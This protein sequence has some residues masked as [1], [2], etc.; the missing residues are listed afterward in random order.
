M[1]MYRDARIS[2]TCS[3]DSEA[4]AAYIHLDHPITAGA[5][6][7]MIPFDPAEGMFNLD[8]DAEGHV[9]GLEILAAR[10]ALPQALLAAII[11]HEDTEI[12][13]R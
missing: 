11:D 10:S 12:Q 1:T 2:L 9:L 5:A 7:R 8:L 3:Y 13:K 6:K 4:N